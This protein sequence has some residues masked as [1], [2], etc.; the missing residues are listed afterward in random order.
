[1]L[2]LV[3]LNMLGVTRLPLP[4]AWSVAVGFHAFF[5]RPCHACW[6][7]V[8]HDHPARRADENENKASASP[9]YRL[10]DVL[11]PWVAFIVLPVFGFANAGVSL[12]G[13]NLETML[14]PLSLGIVLGLFAGKQLGIMAF[15]VAGAGPVSSN[16]RRAPHGAR[17]MA[18]LSYAASASR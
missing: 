5:R 10:E 13:V 14:A 2:G 11:G 1:M 8:G 16:F 7:G 4:G 9:L 12:T 3:V 17:S 18:S 15:I 6:R